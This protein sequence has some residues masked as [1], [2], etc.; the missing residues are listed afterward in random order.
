VAVKNSSEGK[1][2]PYGAPWAHRKI[3]THDPAMDKNGELEPREPMMKSQARIMSYRI[4][5][6]EPSEEKRRW[7]KPNL[8][9]PVVPDLERKSPHKN[10]RTKHIGDKTQERKSEFLLGKKLNTIRIQP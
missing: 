2:K 1:M 5:A 4:Q 3:R 10:A 9:E 6:E 8:G 7:E